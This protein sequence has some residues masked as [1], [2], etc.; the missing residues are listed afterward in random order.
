MKPFSFTLALAAL[1]LL[2]LPLSAQRAFARETIVVGDVSWDASHAVSNVLKVIIEDKLGA[3]VKIVPA[4]GM[5]PFA[6]GVDK[7]D[8]SFD[9]HPDF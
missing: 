9:V 1:L 7:G 6:A 2:A 4:E 5:S 3:D 8:G